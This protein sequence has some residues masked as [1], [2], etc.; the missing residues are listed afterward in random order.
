MK[1]ILRTVS[2][3]AVVAAALTSGG[4]ASAVSLGVNWVNN[5]GGGVQNASTD[6]LG[7]D[8]SAVWSTSTS[9]DHAALAATPTCPTWP[10]SAP[11][12]T[13]S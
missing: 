13:N 1:Q 8:E 2:L 5:N 9:P 7:P 10:G 4:S 3:I 6:S 12:C 11:T